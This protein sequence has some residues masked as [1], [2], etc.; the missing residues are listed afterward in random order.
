MNGRINKVALHHTLRE[1]DQLRLLFSVSQASPS[2]NSCSPSPKSPFL[3]AQRGIF[4]NSCFKSMLV[5]EKST[6]AVYEDWYHLG[7]YHLFLP[8][9]TIDHTNLQ[10]H[11]FLKSKAFSWDIHHTSFQQSNLVMSLQNT[12]DNFKIGFHPLNPIAFKV[13]SLSYEV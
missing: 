2:S 6:S 1:A 10:K 4:L 8:R 11:V 13:S 7:F 5:F 12:L 9:Q 3:H